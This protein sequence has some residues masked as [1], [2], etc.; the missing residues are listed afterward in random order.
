MGQLGR[1]G[2]GRIA[3]ARGYHF[4]YRYIWNVLV[5]AELPNHCNIFYRLSVSCSRCAP[6]SR[7]LQ[8]RLAPS[9]LIQAEP[10]VRYCTL[11]LPTRA[12]EPDL[13]ILRHMTPAKSAELY[14]ELPKAL[15]LPCSR[16]SMLP[17]SGGGRGSWVELAMGGSQS[18]E[19][20]ILCTLTY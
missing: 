17:R 6:C 1:A 10:F 4:V 11:K 19:G 20:T 12:V 13:D 3:I 7:R 15:L 8:S 18:H 16:V 14:S 5:A 2:D 9:E